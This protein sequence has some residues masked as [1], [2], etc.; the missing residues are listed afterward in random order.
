MHRIWARGCAASIIARRTRAGALIAM[1]CAA[2]SRMCMPHGRMATRPSHA[3]GLVVRVGAPSVARRTCAG[4]LMLQCRARQLA[5]TPFFSP[6]GR[7]RPGAASNA[8]SVAVSCKAPG[9]VT[10]SPYLGLSVAP[11]S[12]WPYCRT[13]NVRCAFV[14]VIITRVSRVVLVDTE[15]RY[16]A[17]SQEHRLSTWLYMSCNI[18]YISLK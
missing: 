9:N 13:G 17:E 15:S 18:V 7:D 3:F 14:F 6:A 16:L 11:L 1:P 5:L 10:Y 12:C 8:L 4:A 2:A